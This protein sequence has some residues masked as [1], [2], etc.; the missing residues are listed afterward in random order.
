M[1]IMTQELRS[2]RVRIMIPAWGAHKGQGARKAIGIMGDSLRTTLR[3]QVA[4][5]L[6]WKIIIALTLEKIRDW[7]MID[8]IIKFSPVGSL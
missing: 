6:S 1:R 4:V 3:V 5:R 2:I 7:S 8:I